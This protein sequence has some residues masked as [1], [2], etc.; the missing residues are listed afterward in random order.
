MKPPLLSWLLP[1]GLILHPGFSPIAFAAEPPAPLVVHEW[2]TFTSLQNEQGKAIGGINTD[3]EPVPPFVHRLADLLLLRPTEVPIIFSQGAPR[4]HPDVT[5]RLE[6][7]VVYFHPSEN[8]PTLEGLTLTAKFHGGWLSEFYPEAEAVSPGVK[9]YSSDFGPLHSDTVSTLS[10]NNLKI[11]GDWKGP[12]TDAHVWTAPRA[13]QA[14]SVQTT[15]GESEKFLF[16]RGVAHIDAPI[17]ITRDSGGAELI[18]R[19]QCPPALTINGPLPVRYLWLVDID[20]DGQVA[21]RSIAPVTLDGKGTILT[22]VSNRFPT[23][24]HKISNRNKLK[25]SLR[26]ALVTDGLFADEAQALLDTW[27][28]SYFKSPGLRLF[29]LVPRAWTDSYL[30]LTLSRPAELTRVMVGRIELVTQKQRFQLAEL[31]RFTPENITNDVTHLR[32]S[33]YAEIAGDPAASQAVYNDNE[34]IGK[35]ISVPESYRTYLALGRFRNAL[36]LD[37]AKKHPSRGLN[38]FIST[39]RLEAYKPMAMD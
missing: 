1:I 30:P 25:A 33:F 5:M 6:T 2:G 21:F 22:R 31:A 14:A 12:A 29:F 32:A 11:G 39:Y 28:L 4:C 8:N 10:W 19:D 38:S 7:P 37:E 26:D 34:P 15:G 20:S 16:Y 9:L 36:V 17:A 3:D 13:A 24:E 35:Y 23:E 27:E 18:L